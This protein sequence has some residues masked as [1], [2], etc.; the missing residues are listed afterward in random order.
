MCIKIILDVILNSRVVAQRSCGCLILGGY[1]G[2]V[3][4]G[5]L[6]RHLLGGNLPMTGGL[7]QDDL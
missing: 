2:Q 7:E 1:Q 6:G 5:R 3:G 4:W